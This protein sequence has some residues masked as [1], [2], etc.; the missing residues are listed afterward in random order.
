VLKRLKRSLVDSYVGAIA[1][2]YLLAQDVLHF[3]GI[4]ASPL[5]GWVTRKEYGDILRRNGSVAAFSLQEALPEAAKFLVL[6]LVWYLLV[7]WL[8]FK[9][10]AT[11]T[12][13]ASNAERV[14]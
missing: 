11:A 13:Q 8:Y 10:H 1:L 7:R 6:L 12:E 5:A 9:P 3:V 2:G 14:D 4:F